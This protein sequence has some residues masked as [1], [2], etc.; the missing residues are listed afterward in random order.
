MEQSG[1]RVK[2]MLMPILQ[3]GPEVGIHLVITTITTTIRTFNTKRCVPR[4]L[5]G[6][7][8]KLK[9]EIEA[10]AGAGIGGTKAE[11]LLG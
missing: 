4:F 10:K 9:N 7:L 5:Y 11:Y 2:D 8:V 1:E 6:W 3:K